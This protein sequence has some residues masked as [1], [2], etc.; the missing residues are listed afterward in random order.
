MI[1][2][3][4]GVPETAD[5][6]DRVRAAIGRES[7]ALQLP[8][9]G[10]PRPERFGGTKDDYVAWLVGELGA[11][12]EPV[13]LVGHDWGAALTWRVATAHGDLLR[14]WVADIG[15]IAH[16]DYVWHD[17]AK[18]W[19][20]PGEGEAFFEAQNASPP[21][22]RAPLYEAMGI[23]PDDALK[24]ASAGDETM[25]ASILGLYRSALPNAFAAWGPWSPTSAPGLVLHPT[26]DPFSDEKMAAEVATQ[27]GARFEKL[28]GAGHFWPYQ[29]P[30]KAAALLEAFWSSL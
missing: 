10:C 12:G 14:S 2:F 17:F 9:F 28:D 13:D 29:A 24:M 18:I 8:G 11:I 6:W 23:P 19:Q 5:I 1:V 26:D 27:L 25:G 21:D 30:D 20:T 16:A 22:Q 7:V 4:H 3:L 15:N